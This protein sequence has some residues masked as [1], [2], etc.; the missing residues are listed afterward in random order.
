MNDCFENSP[1]SCI[2]KMD[3][4]D[5]GRVNAIYIFHVKIVEIVVVNL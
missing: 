5:H 2:W 4:M 1:T 3:A